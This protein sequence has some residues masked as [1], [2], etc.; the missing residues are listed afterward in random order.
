MENLSI[1]RPFAN[2]SDGVLYVDETGLVIYSPTLGEERYVKREY[3]R[4]CGTWRAYVNFDGVQ[5]DILNALHKAFRPYVQGY[6]YNRHKKRNASLADLI[7]LPERACV[8]PCD[9]LYIAQ[10][11]NGNILAAA[12]TITEFA[13]QLAGQI[14]SKPYI[15][16]N[17]ARAYYNFNIKTQP[18][19]EI[20]LRMSCTDENDPQRYYP[21]ISGFTFPVLRAYEST[22]S[23]GRK[24]IYNLIR[25]APVYEW[26]VYL[27]WIYLLRSSHDETAIQMDINESLL[28]YSIRRS[29]ITWFSSELKQNPSILKMIF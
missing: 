8:I 22:G 26:R 24:A 4:D 19:D 23:L 10:A 16:Y 27:R 18:I 3:E 15:V 20:V 13:E 17:A 6:A 25:S 2:V 7:I 9:D 1:A 14:N 11:L 21:G 5:Y 12:P 28:K 29:A